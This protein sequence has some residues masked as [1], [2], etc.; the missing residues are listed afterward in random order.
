M[1]CPFVTSFV[2]CERFNE[3]HIE[4][5]INLIIFLKIGDVIFILKISFFSYGSK[6]LRGLRPRHFTT[7]HDHTDRHTT[8]GRTPLDEG[9]ARRRELYLTTHNTH[10]RQ[11][12]MPPLG[13]EPTILVS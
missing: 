8:F 4:V 3:R 11:T 12:S 1:Q 10:K 13:F 7:L 5:K 2:C 6:A 9:P